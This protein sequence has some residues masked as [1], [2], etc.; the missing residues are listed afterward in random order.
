MSARILANPLLYVRPFICP[1]LECCIFNCVHLKTVTQAE[2][3][4]SSLAGWLLC[5]GFCVPANVLALERWLLETSPIVLL[6]LCNYCLGVL[7]I[8]CFKYF[9]IYN[10]KLTFYFIANCYCRQMNFAVCLF[11]KKINCV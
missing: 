10:F 6:S 8:L 5:C 11:F 1:L 4:A 9:F 2:Q 7:G 3:K